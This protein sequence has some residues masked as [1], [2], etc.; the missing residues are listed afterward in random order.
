MTVPNDL[1]AYGTSAMLAVLINEGYRV[2]FTQGSSGADCAVDLTGPLGSQAA[3]LGESPAAALAS[4]WPLDTLPT[5]DDDADEEPGA[6]D[7]TAAAV[8]AEKITALREYVGRALGDVH[9]DG[10]GVLERVAA[11]LGRISVILAAATERVDDDDEDDMEPFCTR[12]G[13]WIGHFH[14]LDGWRHFRGDPAPGGQ[15]ELY[16][17]DHEAAPAWTIPAGRSLSPADMTVM[18][19]ALVVAADAKQDAGFAALLVRLHEGAL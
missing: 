10:L 6:V 11:D 12:C 8:L 17:A 18:R 15:R 9:H 2:T 3:G 7:A 5:E 14:G 13:E 16:D 1:P 19:R 4:V